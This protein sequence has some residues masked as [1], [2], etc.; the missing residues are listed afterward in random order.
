MSTFNAI[1]LAQGKVC[2]NYCSKMN[3]F[4]KVFR[5]QHVIKSLQRDEQQYFVVNIL[6][7]GNYELNSYTV[8]R[9]F[10]LMVKELRCYMT[11]KLR[12]ILPYFNFYIK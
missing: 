12:L 7:N 4:S 11:Q 8:L 2:D 5:G 3:H 6:S 9:M 1:C 10:L